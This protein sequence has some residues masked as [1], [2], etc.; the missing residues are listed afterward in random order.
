MSLGSKKPRT[1]WDEKKHLLP[2]PSVEQRDGFIQPIV[3]PC[4]D[5]K[6]EKCP[7]FKDICHILTTSGDVFTDDECMRML[8]RDI[9]PASMRNKLPENATD[10]ASVS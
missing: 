8:D 2:H 9:D 10:S 4:L 7:T 5:I 3:I 1:P 6:P